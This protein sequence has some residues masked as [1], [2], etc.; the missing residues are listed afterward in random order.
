M[1][2]EEAVVE[3]VKKMNHFQLMSLHVSMSEVLKSSEYCISLQGHELGKSANQAVKALL[4][5]T[6]GSID[7]GIKSMV[8]Q[9]A[10]SSAL[11][12]SDNKTNDVHLEVEPVQPVA[13]EA[14]E[15]REQAENKSSE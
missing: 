5:G 6:M 15:V 7:S 10:D 2:Q 4:M 13:A 8:N 3:K 9:S 12:A 11:L 14:P 1:S